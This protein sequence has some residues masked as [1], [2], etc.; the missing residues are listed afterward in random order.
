MPQ[1]YV[2]ID[3][4]TTGLD[5]VRDAIIEVGAVKFLGDEVVETYSSFV[6]PGR[7][8]PQAITDLTGITDRDVADAPSLHG[9]VGQI[10]EFVG[11]LPVVGHSVDFDLAFLHRQSALLGSP[12]FDTFELSTVLF[13]ILEKYSLTSLTERLGIE[14]DRS[15]RALDDA[16]ASFRLFRLLWLRARELPR[17]TLNDIVVQGSRAGW[18]AVGFFERALHEREVGPA[19]RPKH[20]GHGRPSEGLE[21][22]SQLVP[23]TPLQP[24]AELMPL[25]VSELEGMLGERGSMACRFPNYEP[26]PQQVQM[27]RAVASAFNRGEHL[28]VEAPTGVGKSL[29]YLIPAVRWGVTNGEHVVIST[30][31]INLQEQLLRKDLPDLRQVLQVDFRAS[32]LKGRAHYLCPARLRSLRRRGAR[33]PDEARVLARVLVWMLGTHDGDGDSLFLPGAVDRALWR[34]LSADHEGCIPE[35]CRE[36]HNRNCHFY[37]ARRAAEA[38]HVVIVNH[39]LVLADIAVQNRSL[40]DYDYLI[41]DEAHNLEAATTNGLSF[42]SSEAGLKRLIEEVGSLHQSGR[43]TGLL[44]EA[45]ALCQQS[46]LAAP[47]ME[48]IELHIGH[49]GTAASRA[50]GQC[51]VFFDRL[52]DFAEEQSADRRSRYTRRLLVTPAHRIQPAWDLVEMEWDGTSA[53]ITAMV[54]GLEKVARALNE[55]T[56]VEPDDAADLSANITAAARR[57]SDVQDRIGQLVSEPSNSEIYWIEMG[58]HRDSLSLHV[59]PLHVGQLLERYLFGKKRSVI[60][61]SAT[62]RTCGSFDFVRERLSAWDAAELAVG[63]PFDYKKSTLVYLVDDIPEPGHTGYQRAVEE[64]LVAL[65]KATEGRTLIL[66]TSYRQLSATARAITA[67]LARFGIQVRAQGDGGSR[68]QLLDDF[69]TGQRRVLL[70]TRSFWEGVDVPG[71]ALSCLA[72]VKMP[73]DVPSDPVFASRAQTFEQPFVEYALPNAILRFRQGFGRLIRSRKD[74]GIV[75]VFDRRLITK[76]YGPMFLESLP[77][78]TLRRGSVT[79]LASVAAEWLA[80]ERSAAPS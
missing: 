15:H 29:A 22:P 37:R 14:T 56:D 31:T 26:R 27:L 4:E 2:A 79:R 64:G 62:L 17:D 40:P 48:R 71:D 75:A 24:A 6:D 61:T 41:V 70:G 16:L 1:T 54:Q 63:T 76:S 55:M 8:I 25:D 77:D 50:V 32:V 38:S 74:R 33:S 21:N 46:H 52:A 20:G 3:L 19:T 69:R 68:A 28:L 58:D 66:F 59:A 7:P 12:H 67:P 80:S 30:N 73:F 42:E 78:P 53:P 13:P 72:L 39:A 36:F 23:S 44:G 35:R 5:P 47:Q 43:V 49:V 60:L 45:V 10:G 11:Q 51:H 18:D 57:I 9:V 65:C 34:Q